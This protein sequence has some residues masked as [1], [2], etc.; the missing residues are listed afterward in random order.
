[1]VT[2]A[3]FSQWHR[4]TGE[5]DFGR[6]ARRHLRAAFSALPSQSQFNRLVR[7]HEAWITAFFGTLAV[8]LGRADEGYEAL[9]CTA[10]PIRN[11]K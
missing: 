10:A 11:C 7:Q 5:R 3:L 2:L 1:M 4:F 9:D 8:A 6:W